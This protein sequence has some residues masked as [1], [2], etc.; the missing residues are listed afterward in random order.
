M[1]TYFQKIHYSKELKPKE[2]AVL[3]ILLF[4]SFFYGIGIFFRN[5]LYKFAVLKSTK[6]NAYTI[7]IGNLTTG[8]TGKTPITCEIANYI[9]KTLNKKTAVISRGYGGKLS[10]KKTNIISDGQ[11]I[12]YDAVQAGDEPFW[13]ATNAQ[14]TAV[15]T[16]KNR[17]K[18]GQYAIDN[19]NSEVLILDD[20]FQHLKLKRDLDIVL[21]DSSNVFGNGFLLPAGPLREAEIHIKRADK[22]IIVNKQ[23][24]N[25]GSQ[26]QC[27]E[28]A[29]MITQK[30][31]KT[32]MICSFQYG[33]IYDLKTNEP[34]SPDKAF[35][36][37][38][39]AQPEFF[40]NYLKQNMQ[41]VEQKVF[42]DHC[43]YNK[44]DIEN[45]ILKAEEKKADCLIT[46]EK[47]AVKILPFINEISSNIKI[48]ALKLEVD[49]N[50]E[51]LT[52]DLIKE[53]K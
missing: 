47:D 36:F 1:K 52:E 23:P 50:I 16:G 3:S 41:L 51:N 10:N 28:V 24:Y 40:F 38:G 44:L 21:I 42:S 4:A 37:A 53:I 9:T 7:S 30:Y 22:I 2:T 25:T 39:I 49:L 12:F 6:L 15:L 13:M 33:K 5:L 43:L 46:T 20:G 32:A 45:L 31:Q 35:V 27:S 26:E 17:V 19:F 29:A 48:C 18:S 8:G 11:N 14:N 34:V